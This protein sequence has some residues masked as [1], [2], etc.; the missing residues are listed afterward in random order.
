MTTNKEKA[1]RLVRDAVRR[2]DLVR[3]K[4]C[5]KCG[6]PGSV[7]K[8]G[9]MTIQGHHKDYSRPLDVEWLC[10]KCHRK[11]TPL[12]ASFAE[13]RRIFYGSDNRQAK[14]HESLIPEIISSAESIRAFARKRGVSR[15]AISRVR[16][17]KYWAARAALE[18]LSDR[19]E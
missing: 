7:S 19:R 12:P 1:G 3:P 6:L 16:S 4:I 18:A 17:G 8:D 10:A 9:R 5:E 11:V 14:L 15:W 13:K 2:G